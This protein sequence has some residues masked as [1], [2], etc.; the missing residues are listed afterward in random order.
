MASLGCRSRRSVVFA[1]CAAP[2]GSADDLEPGWLRR[3]WHW[4]TL[5]VA[6]LVF[7]V[8]LALP[9]QLTTWRPELPPTWIEPV[10]AGL[11]LGTVV[12]LGLIG[13]ALLVLV[14]IPAQAG[15]RRD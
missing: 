5:V 6:S 10:V 12:V 1:G 3:A 14:S 4:R 11:R 13:C 2:R 7:V 9:W 15:L 8:L